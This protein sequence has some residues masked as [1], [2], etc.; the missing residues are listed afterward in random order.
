MATSRKVQGSTKTRESVP[1][2]QRSAAGGP[3]PEKIAARAYEIWQE[4]G[5]PEG[6]DAENWYRAERE[7]SSRAKPV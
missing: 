1:Q 3:A 2:A 6:K 4:S 5:R 7:L